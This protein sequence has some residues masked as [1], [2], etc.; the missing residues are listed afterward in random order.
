MSAPRRAPVKLTFVTPV[1]DAPEKDWF[2]TRYRDLAAKVEKTAADAPAARWVELARHWNELRCVA[3]GE[4]SRRSW[5]ESCD[6]RDEAAEAAANRFRNETKPLTV[7]EDAVLRRRFLE[8]QP[9]AALEREF[10]ATLLALWECEAI[11]SDPVNVDLD[12]EANNLFADYQRIRGKAEVELDGAKRTLTQLTNMSESPDAGLR[13]RSFDALNGFYRE[14]QGEFDK[15]YG[16]LVELRTQ[17]G[18]NLGY[19]NYVPLGYK[20]MSRTD[21]GPAEAARLRE[22]IAEH[23]TP[24]A[25]DIRARQAKDLGTKAVMAWDRNFF[26]AYSLPE[27]VVPVAGQVE[28]ARKVFLALHPRL[29]A[30]FDHMVSSG[31]ADIDNRPGKQPGGY[32]TSMPDTSEVRIFCNSTGAASDVETLVHES[33]HSFQ[34][35]ESQKIEMCDLRVPTMDAAE[36]HS[37]GMEYLSFPHVQAFFANDE[38]TTR[39]KRQKLAKSIVFLPYACI[40]DAFQH[41]VYERP[42]MT[43]DERA[44]TWARIWKRFIPD[45]DWSGHEGALARRWHRQLHI[46]GAPFYYIDYALAETCALQLY[47][48]SKRDPKTALERYLRLC[49]IGGSRSF[50][51]I[52]KEG[53]LAN[54][55]DEG[56][57]P[58][59]MKLAREELGL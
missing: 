32:C 29:L 13:R 11:G 27:N 58:P 31:L 33:G 9:R 1:P 23:V 18:K 28:A 14:K 17:S 49:E 15:I 52:V 30:H 16:R 25:R 50:L 40:V 21:Y 34:G 22:L 8:A 37:M 38:Q 2:A 54:P 7:T 26:S 12:V 5:D 48:L 46:F 35:W 4:D 59:L 45:E 36:I 19:T 10:G 24:L 43:P 6:V 41:E 20:R 53:G 44:E 56:T 3:Q 57:L 55:F 39:F 42:S 47:A 51:G